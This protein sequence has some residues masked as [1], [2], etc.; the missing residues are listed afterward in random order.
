MRAVNQLRLVNHMAVLSGSHA[1]NSL[2]AIRECFDAGV[3][4]I[5][6]DVHSLAGDDYIVSH[7]RRLDDHTSGVGAMGRVTPD[8][9]RAS[10][11]INRPDDRPAL[12]SEVVA[13]AR[14]ASTEIQLDLKD[15][16]PLTAE[17]VRVLD[18][19]IAPVR[20]RVIVSSGQDWNLMRLRA[21][22]PKIAFGFDPGHYLAHPTEDPSA[23]LPR[24]AGAYG[25]RDDHP[26][27]L[28]RAAETPEYLRE[29]FELLLLQ[30]PGG[31]EFFLNYR[32][33]LHMLNDGFNA[34]EC[35]H[36]RRVDANV[37]T[38]DY[39]GPES[40]PP[41]ARLLDAGF[42]RVTTNTPLAWQREFLD[43]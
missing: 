6:V 14:D 35:L 33:A 26:L 7:D 2:A 10:R 11:F 27:A 18:D 43:R 9:V 28:G 5:E 17:R 34:A 1:R 21:S 22:A 42:D 32:F 39:H 23:P 25:Y 38:P 24:T 20:D 40:V 15:W 29:R 16:R 31:R 4:R 36:E 12:L 41:I 30:V 8:D 13:L 37:W 3:E 19:L